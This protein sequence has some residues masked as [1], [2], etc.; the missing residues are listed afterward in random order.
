MTRDEGE[1]AVA[2]A[3]RVSPIS[4]ADVGAVADFLHTNLNA[5]VTAEAWARA[6]DVPWK[7]DAPNHGFMLV[8]D[9]AVIGAYLAF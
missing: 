9:G 3:I 7:V 8:E 5:R 2:M 1:T 4:G 6:M